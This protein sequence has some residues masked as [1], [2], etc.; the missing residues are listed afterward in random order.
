MLALNWHILAAAI[1]T[2]FSPEMTAV[3]KDISYPIN[4]KLR[5]CSSNIEMINIFTEAIQRRQ[6]QIQSEIDTELA[7]VALLLALR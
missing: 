5:V 6:T 4:S 2:G 7:T 3:E 1:A